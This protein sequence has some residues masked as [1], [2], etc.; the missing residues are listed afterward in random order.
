MYKD[1]VGGCC[2]HKTFVM[3]FIYYAPKI[4]YKYSDVG[5]K[6]QG[7]RSNKYFVWVLMLEIASIYLKADLLFNSRVK[8]IPYSF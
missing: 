5:D 6:R 8:E 2:V 7:K 4:S 1:L 3:G